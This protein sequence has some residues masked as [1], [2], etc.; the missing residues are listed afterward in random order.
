[1]ICRNYTRQGNL[2]FW[3]NSADLPGLLSPQA[4][5]FMHTTVFDLFKRRLP[6]RGD[7]ALAFSAAA[8]LVF[9]WSLRGLFFNFP[10]YLLS[11]NIWEILVI[12]AYMMSFALFETLLA[13]LLMT[14]LAAILPAPL[15]KDG[16]S[17]KA[18]FFFVAFGI[19]SIH[20]QLVMTNQPTVNFLLSEL[21]RGL[22]LWLVPVLL[23]R[24]VGV[25][26]KIVLDVLDRLVIFSYV[27]LPL[28]VISVFVIIVRLLW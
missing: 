11:Y 12:A 17:Y 18:S 15:L 27:Y 5:I 22:L 13:A 21:G 16:F 9:S 24:Y 2:R 26:R 6:A 4:L 19:I 28:G 7:T 14:G 8:F 20:L 10:A 3:Y 1:M 23:T 25:V